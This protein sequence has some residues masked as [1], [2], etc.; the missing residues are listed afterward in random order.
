MWIK[1]RPRYLVHKP[2]G[3]QIQFWNPFTTR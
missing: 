3:I 1:W 2:T